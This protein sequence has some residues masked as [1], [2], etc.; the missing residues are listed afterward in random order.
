[1]LTLTLAFFQY[2]TPREK[3][4]HS[5]FFRPTFSR[6]RTENG[7][8]LCKSTYSVRMRKNKDQ[9]NLEYRHLSCKCN[10]ISEMKLV[11]KP[12]TKLI[13]LSHGK[14][15]KQYITDLWICITKRKMIFYLILNFHIM[16]L[17]GELYSLHI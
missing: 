2:L 9:K 14:Y 17:I 5:E 3:C 1:M 13:T 16:D 7:D 4:P 10:L 12:I 6:I 15:Q 8:L 11:L